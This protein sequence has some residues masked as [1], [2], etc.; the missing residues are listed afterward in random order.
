MKTFKQNVYNPSNLDEYKEVNSE[1]PEEL[2]E[3]IKSSLD[4]IKDNFRSTIPVIVE[5][6]NVYF[7]VIYEEDP[8]SRYLIKIEKI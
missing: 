1:I 2:V 7:K 8:F 3:S 4:N 6:T 5:N